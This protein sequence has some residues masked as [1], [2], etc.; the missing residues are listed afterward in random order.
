MGTNPQV[1]VDLVVF[2]AVHPRQP[3]TEWHEAHNQTNQLKK[4]SR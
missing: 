4:L 2:C 1:P 3:E